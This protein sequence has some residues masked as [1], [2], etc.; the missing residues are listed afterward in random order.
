MA[1]RVP[2]FPLWEI[3]T[4]PAVARLSPT[5]IG[6]LVLL[7]GALWAS[8]DMAP[9]AQQTA[10]QALARAGDKAWARNREK[11]LAAYHALAPDLA[12]ALAKGQC[13]IAVRQ[14][15]AANAR[16]SKARHRLTQTTAADGYYP[17]APQSVAGVSPI[18][19]K[20]AQR[21]HPPHGGGPIGGPRG[22]MMRD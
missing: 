21:P 17:L 19:R 4:D 18:L 8:G 10:V 1:N 11:V 5:A 13:I 7:L 22:G 14:A 2:P 16:A 12:R 6:H 9:P 15:G 3:L 20:L